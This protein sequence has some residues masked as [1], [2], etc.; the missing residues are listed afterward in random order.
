METRYYCVDNELIESE[1]SNFDILGSWLANR[2]A[3]NRI[4]NGPYL[5]KFFDTY[6]LGLCTLLPV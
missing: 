4:V 5:D 6:N 2:M 1:S 3:Y